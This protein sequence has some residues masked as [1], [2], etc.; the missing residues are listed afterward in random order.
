MTA[1]MLLPI[2]GSTWLQMPTARPMRCVLVDVAEVVAHDCELTARG[3][4]GMVSWVGSPQQFLAEFI[5]LA[6][7]CYPQ[8]AI[9]ESP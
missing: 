2:P 8:S 6:A 7:Q 9:L 4:R 5:P 1:S 3:P